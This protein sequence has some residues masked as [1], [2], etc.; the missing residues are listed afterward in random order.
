MP[1]K[2]P[3]RL[4]YL[5][6]TK[7]LARI[8]FNLSGWLV[9]PQKKKKAVL[10]THSMLESLLIC[11]KSLRNLFSVFFLTLVFKL[12]IPGIWICIL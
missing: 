8:P 12:L 7:K 1:G 6:A 4:K 5:A 9:F 11:Y 2:K 10:K 3:T